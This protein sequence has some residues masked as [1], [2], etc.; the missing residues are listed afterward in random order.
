MNII[1]LLLLFLTY[2]IYKQWSQFPDT[3]HKN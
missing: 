3:I 1:E 2:N